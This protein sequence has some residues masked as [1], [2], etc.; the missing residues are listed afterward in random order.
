[1]CFHKSKLLNVLFWVFISSQ[2][3]WA[4]CSLS[5]QHKEKTLG[6]FIGISTFCYSDSASEV[7]QESYLLKRFL[8]T[9][10]SKTILL[11]EKI[12]PF[13]LYPFKHDGETFAGYAVRKKGN[14]L[15]QNEIGILKKI[16]CSDKNYIFDNLMK[17]CMFTPILGLEFKKG[18]QIVQVLICLDCD[19]WRFVGQN[20]NKEEDFDA[21][22]QMIVNYLRQIFP[23]D[24]IVKQLH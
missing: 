18:T 15:T 13:L 16:I 11:A 4:D 8:G 6:V 2:T 10:A 5:F 14:E 12:T 21:V 3:T 20:L 1:M 17:N 9:N 7:L 22:H 23:T 19:V 24:S